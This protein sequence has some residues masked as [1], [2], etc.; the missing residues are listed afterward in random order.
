MSVGEKVQ[1]EWCEASSWSSST[2][3]T[4]SSVALPSDQLRHM[5][6]TS[7]PDCVVNMGKS[8][9]IGVPS[10]GAQRAASVAYWPG[11]HG[12]QVAAPPCSTQASWLAR[13]VSRMASQGVAGPVAMSPAVAPPP[14]EAEQPAASASSAARGRPLTIPATLDFID[15]MGSSS[16]VC[17][18]LASVED[19][20]DAVAGE[21]QRVT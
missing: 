6:I 15:L 18:A 10:S 2:A 13:Q 21:T 20:V 4:H 19:G 1:L 11:G 12:W 7:P 17:A 9:V 16:W 8:W 14:S 3:V 5:P